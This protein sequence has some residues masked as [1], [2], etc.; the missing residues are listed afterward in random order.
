LA[1]VHDIGTGVVDSETRFV[2]RCVTLYD[3][4][5]L[6]ECFSLHLVINSAGLAPTGMEG[7]FFAVGSSR[8]LLA[9]LGDMAMGMMNEIYNPNCP[10]NDE[11]LFQIVIDGVSC[12]HEADCLHSQTPILL[13]IILRMQR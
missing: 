11:M 13:V 12:I 6:F 9:P 8:A 4:L 7:L 3:S 5:S 1:G 2:D 10:G